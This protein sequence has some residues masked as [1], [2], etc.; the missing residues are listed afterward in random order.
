MKRTLT[1]LSIITG[2]SVLVLAAGLLACGCGN[3]DQQGSST[4]D[5]YSGVV[6]ASGST[7]VLPI[8][9][10]AATLFMDENPGVSVEIQGGGSSVGIQQVKDGV[11]DIGNSSR[12]LKADEN[13]GSLVDHPI[14]LDV[15]AII[16]H[17]DV[18][19]ADLTTEQAKS[20]F[21]G[22]ITRWSEVGGGDMEI[23]VVVRDQASGTR[24]MFDEKVLGKE[25]EP[26][27]SAIECN[28]NGIVRETVAST[29][30]SIGYVS[31]GYV[32]DSVKPVSFNGVKASLETAR[33]GDYVLS[34]FLHMITR[35]VP[36]GAV[37]GFI[38]FVLSDSFQNQV[39]SKEYI[40][41]TELE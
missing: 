4:E 26:V 11:V 22:E 7:T 32:Q 20:I 14:A 30:N 9:Q 31:E 29:R 18:G 3:Q 19:V 38:D 13:D 1:W 34:R 28:S 33:S 17:P 16:T 8:T 37:K 6:K 10:E 2:L 23:V 40:P 24:E 41:M 15:I 21:T 39:V 25:A 12:D 5:T 36:Q 35:G 27:A